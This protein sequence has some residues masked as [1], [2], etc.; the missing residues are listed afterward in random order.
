MFINTQGVHGCLI[1]RFCWNKEE[2]ITDKL[3]VVLQVGFV[4][5]PAGMKLYFFCIIWD[6]IM[7]TNARFVQGFYVLKIKSK[8]Q[9]N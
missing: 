1:C 2:N 5:R 3:P 4:C 6:D 7:M 8:T 9:L